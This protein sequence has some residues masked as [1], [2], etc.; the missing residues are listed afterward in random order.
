MHNSSG[1]SARS[2]FYLEITT[3]SFA[4]LLARSN[5]PESLVGLRYLEAKLKQ[6]EELPADFVFART[7]KIKTL[8]L[9]AIAKNDMQLWEKAI[10]G[11]TTVLRVKLIFE[12]FGDSII[13]S[14]MNTPF[15]QRFPITVEKIRALHSNYPA[16]PL[17]ILF[18]F[19]VKEEQCSSTY[20]QLEAQTGE[21]IE[22]KRSAT[23]KF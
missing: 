18:V 3:I 22:P 4:C 11:D 5:D 15:M 2:S 19:S 14:L 7:L 6:M 16:G 9:L 23:L 20:P 8:A 1:N 12:Y 10:G 17:P 13:E 21:P